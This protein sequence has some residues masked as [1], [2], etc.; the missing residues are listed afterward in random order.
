[1][2]ADQPADEHSKSSRTRGVTPLPKISRHRGR[3]APDPVY[4]F[5]RSLT[6]GDVPDLRADLAGRLSLESVT[7]QVKHL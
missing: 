1:M 6:C 5:L 3:K 4:G 7:V 2:I